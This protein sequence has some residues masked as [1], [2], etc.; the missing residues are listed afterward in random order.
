VRIWDA[1]SGALL[2]TLEGHTKS[3]NSANFSA[4]GQFIMSASYDDTVRIWEVASGKQLDQFENT[5]EGHQQ[6]LHKY[7]QIG[8]H[9]LK[10]ANG[11]VLIRSGQKLTVRDGQRTYTF[12]GDADIY[13]ASWAPDGVHLVVGDYVGRVILLRVQE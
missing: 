7:P 1:N 3:V 12:Y 5:S 13:S 9:T 2:K 8:K 4:D 6:A 11:R 10:H